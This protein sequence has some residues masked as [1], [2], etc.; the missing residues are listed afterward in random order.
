MTA[1]LRVNVMHERKNTEVKQGSALFPH[2]SPSLL[3]TLFL[4]FFRRIKY[5][6]NCRSKRGECEICGCSLAH[7]QLIVHGS[8]PRRISP[9]RSDILTILYNARH[10]GIATGK[11]KHLG[12][13]GAIVLRVILKE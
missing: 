13:P 12:A 11:R 8:T 1:L 9:S 5:E 6:A 10:S 7:G 2:K 3:R 4:T